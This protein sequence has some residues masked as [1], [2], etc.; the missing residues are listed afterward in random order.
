MVQRVTVDLNSAFSVFTADVITY[1]FYGSH[2]DYLSSKDLKH[3]LR[4]A[5]LALLGFYNL[6]R[7]LPISPTTIKNLPIPILGLLNHNRSLVMSARNE[8]KD[9][10]LKS[11][12]SDRETKS[13]S[14]S[15]IISALTDPN[16][17]AEEKTIDRLL[18]EGQTI[19]FAG[20]DT[21]ARALSVAMFHLLNDKRH[22]QKLRQELNSLSKQAGQTWTAAQLEALPFMVT[23]IAS[24]IQSS[25]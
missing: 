25:T 15:V 2:Q 10:I 14:K 9:K 13:K 12:N 19:I 4:D 11:L 24:F 21:T 8:N 17:P 6:M 16:V 7:F 23:I 20:V 3:H 22:L 18:D 5:L 1:H